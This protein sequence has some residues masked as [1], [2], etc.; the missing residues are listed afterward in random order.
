[1]SIPCGVELAAHPW[2]TFRHPTDHHDS[3]RPE[4]TQGCPARLERS[5]PPGRQ[6][7]A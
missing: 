3:P 7:E 2:T 6:V 4:K 5:N 1:M